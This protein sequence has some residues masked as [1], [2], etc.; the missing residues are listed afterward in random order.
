MHDPLV[1]SRTKPIGAFYDT[2][3][4]MTNVQRA[5]SWQFEDRSY[6][7]LEKLRSVDH[8]LEDDGSEIDEVIQDVILGDSQRVERI[9]AW[10]DN[11][12]FHI[13]LMKFG[14]AYW[15]SA[16][17]FDHVGLFETL[18]DARD[19]ALEYFSSFIEALDERE[20]EPD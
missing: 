14:N 5:I 19:F 10:G 8:G 12:I 18:D 13:D 1:C 15:V 11:E 7:I 3:C 9:P 20:L 4:E 2:F 16:I 6:E 17:E